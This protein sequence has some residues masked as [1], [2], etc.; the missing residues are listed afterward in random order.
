VFEAQKRFDVVVWGVP[1]CRDDV[2]AIQALPIDTPAGVQVPLRDAAEV[3][4]VPMPNE[5]K[6]ERASRRLDITC[7]VRGRDLGAVAAEV[8][9]KVRAVPFEAGTTRSFW[10]RRRPAARRAS[11]WRCWPGWRCS[12]G[13]W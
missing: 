4:V 13:C 7:N 11:G 12:G 9:Q 10:A 6:R 1:A 3:L 5:M 2:S 8:E